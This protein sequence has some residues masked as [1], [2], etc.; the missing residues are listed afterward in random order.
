MTAQG[1]IGTTAV[2]IEADDPSGIWRVVVLY[3]TGDGYWSQMDLTFDPE[4]QKW[5]GQIPTGRTVEW[6]AQVI[7][8]AGNVSYVTKKG[9]L[10]GWIS[11]PSRFFCRA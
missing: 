4:M 8:G 1:G 6:L 7:D 11:C 3:T 9:T 5:V 10:P 2:K